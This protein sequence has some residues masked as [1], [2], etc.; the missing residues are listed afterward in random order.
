MSVP[1]QRISSATSSD[2]QF[3][4]PAAERRAAS[5]D[6]EWDQYFTVG[7]QS[8]LYQLE[9]SWYPKY[10]EVAVG[11]WYYKN[12]ASGRLISA[13]D[14]TKLILDNQILVQLDCYK[15][16]EIFYSTLVTDVSNINEVDAENYKFARDRYQKTWD[17]AVQLSNF[18]DLYGD[19][20]ITKLEENYNQDISY[21]TNNQRYF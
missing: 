3:Y 11:A 4:D 12:N 14:P 21:Y 19:G 8:I 17:E 1:Y 7:S 16:V 13:F 20:V 15:A 18:Y 10:V 5:L 9:F 2:I 6:V